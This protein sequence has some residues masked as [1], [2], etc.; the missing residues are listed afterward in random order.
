VQI[1]DEEA[2]EKGD[3]DANDYEYKLVGVVC[4]MG[5]AEAGHYLSYINVERDKEAK[6]TSPTER[7][8]WLKIESQTWL[9]FNDQNVSRF[10]FNQLEQTCFGG[11]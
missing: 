11:N 4:H 8:D 3:Q 10:N 2:E 1:S 6:N 5:I 7:E 9:E